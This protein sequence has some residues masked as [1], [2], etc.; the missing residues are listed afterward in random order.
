MTVWE[1]IAFAL[2]VRGASKAERRK[3][4]DEL[5]ELIALTG[6]GE[7]MVHELSGGQRQRVVI[8]RALAVEPKVL[9]LDEPLSALDL[10]LRQHMRTEPYKSIFDPKN[11]QQLGPEGDKKQDGATQ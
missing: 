9:L 5:L 11:L 6:Q 3:H 7:K 10:K 1:N 8:A 2:E 4:A